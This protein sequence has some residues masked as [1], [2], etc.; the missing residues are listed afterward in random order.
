M[1][2]NYKK[3][4]E[5]ARKRYIPLLM[6]CNSKEDTHQYFVNGKEYDCVSNFTHNY[7]PYANFD[8]IAKRYA[9]KH[10]FDGPYWDSKVERISG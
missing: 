2:D 6:V 3:I 7:K 1:S 8:E 5:E 10:G 4:I 9:I